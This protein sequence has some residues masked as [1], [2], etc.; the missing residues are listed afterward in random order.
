MPTCVAWIKVLILVPALSMSCY[1]L[2][3]EVCSCFVLFLVMKVSEGWFSVAMVGDWNGTFVK[4]KGAKLS[5]QAGRSVCRR[6]NSFCTLVYLSCFV[7]FFLPKCFRF[8]YAFSCQVFG[9]F[10]FCLGCGE[11]PCFWTWSLPSFVT[12]LRFLKN[13]PNSVVTFD[14]AESFLILL[15]EMNFRCLKHASNLC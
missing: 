7:F 10:F 15:R 2:D 8:S 1:V 5:R 11:T 12:H 3:F 13:A 9:I 4:F 14:F 6:T